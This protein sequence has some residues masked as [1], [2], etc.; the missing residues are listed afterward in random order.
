MDCSSGTKGDSGMAKTPALV[1]FLAGGLMLAGAGSA[2]AQPK[3]D[4]LLHSQFN[5]KQKDIVLS[6]PTDADK[7][8]CEVKIVQGSKPGSVGYLLVDAKKQPLRRFMGAVKQPIETYS[9]FRDGT[10][11]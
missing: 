11:V 9:Y 5:P 3:V 6:T 4:D 8:G 1:G 7:A 10:E 2:S